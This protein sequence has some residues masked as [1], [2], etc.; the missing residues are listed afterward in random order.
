MTDTKQEQ[1]AEHL[2]AGERH[3]LA[4]PIE[5]EEGAPP[6]LANA[7]MAVISGLIILL[8]VWANIAH[9][10]ELSVAPGAIVAYGSSRAAAHLEGGIVFFLCLFPAFQFHKLL[11]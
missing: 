3:G 9:V 4:L 6:A 2:H 8:L 5:L 7:A 11:P 10:R 1:H